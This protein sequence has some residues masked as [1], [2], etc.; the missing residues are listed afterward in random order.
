MEQQLLKVTDLK[1]EINNHVILTDIH[2]EV[3]KEETVAVI[4]PNGAGKT[5]LYRALLG[6]I[7]YS[8]KVEWGEGVKIGYV[9]QRLY[10]EPD[11]P[12]TTAEFFGLKQ[13]SKGDVA[14]VLAA[15][16]FEKE[17]RLLKSKL[18][19]L[20]G[21]ELQ[22]VLIAWAIVDKPDILLFDEPLTGVDISAEETIYGLLKKLQNQEKMAMMLISHE[23]Q[24]VY[25]YATKVICLNKERL[26]YGPPHEALTAETLM[27]LFGQHISIHDH[28]DHG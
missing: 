16:G 18:G 27:K 24:I 20:S 3:S 8:G 17:G 19:V 12:L 22:R 28:H 1:V 15:V 5:M 6:L 13:Q 2:F 21:G 23:L 14:R 10:V 9:P 26:C 4:G 11:L 7:P 25:Q